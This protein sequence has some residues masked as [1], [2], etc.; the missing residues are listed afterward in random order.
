ML[1]TPVQVLCIVGALCTMGA[2]ALGGCFAAARP[3]KGI[4][5]DLSGVWIGKLTAA[6]SNACFAHPDIS[7]TL[8][9]Q[10]LRID[11]FYKCWLGHDD[12]PT[13][14]EGG[15]VIITQAK[16]WALSLRVMMRGG[17]SCVFQ[18]FWHGDEM[19]GG[20]VCFG[21]QGDR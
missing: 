3:A 16:S 19:E 14:D 20:R 21:A 7:F 18:G 6:C 17:S 11:G 10:G 1:R 8:L 15:T 5:F 13:P 9:G 2:L 4:A 12:C